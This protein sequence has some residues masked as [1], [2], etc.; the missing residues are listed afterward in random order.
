MVVRRLFVGLLAPVFVLS[1]TLQAMSETSQDSD[2]SI[3]AVT[4]S[5]CQVK[6]AK[7]NVFDEFLRSGKGLAGVSLAEKDLKNMSQVHVRWLLHDALQR[8][9]VKFLSENCAFEDALDLIVEA[10]MANRIDMVKLLIRRAQSFIRTKNI[11]IENAK[12]LEFEKDKDL[13]VEF[14]ERDAMTDSIYHAMAMGYRAAYF[15]QKYEKLLENQTAAFFRSKFKDAK[16]AKAVDKY[17]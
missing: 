10:S 9:S 17:K 2:D 11:L 7:P 5:F 13:E 15:P 14:L 6:I 16:F 4:G 1:M 8:K 12:S 3:S